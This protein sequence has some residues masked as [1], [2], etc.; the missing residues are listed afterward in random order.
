MSH[1]DPRN[2]SRTPSANKVCFLSSSSFFVFLFCCC[3]HSNFVTLVCD[4]V[5]NRSRRCVCATK[6]QSTP[7]LLASRTTRDLSITKNQS[8]TGNQPIALRSADQSALF[9]LTTVFFEIISLF[10]YKHTD[11]NCVFSSFFLSLFDFCFFI[12]FRL[13]ISLKIVY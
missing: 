8:W 4:S 6:V 12:L 5:Q 9:P 7:R 3:S 2:A 11:T 13:E 10:T 1:L